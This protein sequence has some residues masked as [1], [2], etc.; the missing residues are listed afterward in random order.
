MLFRPVAFRLPI[1]RGLAFTLSEEFPPF[2][3]SL[4]ERLSLPLLF[5]IIYDSFF[6]IILLNVCKNRAKTYSYEALIEFSNSYVNYGVK[7]GKTIHQK[8]M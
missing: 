2:L 7:A 8:P 5:S 6:A 1:S 3:R 4:S